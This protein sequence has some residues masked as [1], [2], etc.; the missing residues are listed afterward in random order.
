MPGPN[1][2]KVQHD[3]MI[4]SESGLVLGTVLDRKWVVADLL[5]HALSEWALRKQDLGILP[6]V[7]REG[8]GSASSILA[9]HWT[10][11][12]L[13][14]RQ[15]VQQAVALV[16]CLSEETGPCVSGVGLS[17]PADC[18]ALDPCHPDDSV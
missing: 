7:S 1:G 14:W 16:L 8:S 17:E 11:L 18:P 12:D 6:P 2:E 13:A 5:D 9:C 3:Q 10:P 4:V 15:I